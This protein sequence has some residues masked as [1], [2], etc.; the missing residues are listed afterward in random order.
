[1]RPVSIDVFVRNVLIRVNDFV[2]GAEKRADDPRMKSNTGSVTVADVARAAKVSKATAARVLGGYGVASESTREAVNRAAAQLGYV[3]NDLARS[4]STGRTGLIGVVVGD[5]ENAFFSKAVRGISDT[6]RAAGLNV[7]ITNS[8]ET[9]EQEREMVGVLLR[10][11][12]AGLIVAPTDS[13]VVDHLQA[14]IASGTPVVTLDRDL[15]ALDADAVCGA[16]YDAARHVMRRL[17]DHG[18]R[19]IA[20]VTALTDPV[21]QSDDLGGVP[22]SAV[23]ERLR[24]FVDASR[25]AGVAQPEQ[26]IFT[27]AVNEDRIFGIVATLLQRRPRITAVL[28]SDSIIGADVFRALASAGIR[29]PQDLS[30]V[31]WFDA[32]WTRIASPSVSVVDQPTY[33]FGARATE[34]L[35]E[36]LNGSTSAPRKLQIATNLIERGSIGAAP[37]N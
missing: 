20:Y 21:L 2:T 23:R 15:A 5:I 14:A 28:A 34:C 18:H 17:Q 16:D 35:I 32:D 30:F 9:V 36:R 22:I 12:V 26:L 11:R 33:R 24:G 10:Q 19:E 7:I 25:E 4:M 6:A 3:A 13:R 37:G 8:S 29:I 27:N 31:S 1:M